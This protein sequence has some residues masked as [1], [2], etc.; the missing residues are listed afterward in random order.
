MVT[1]ER[2]TGKKENKMNNSKRPTKEWY[3][4]TGIKWLSEEEEKYLLKELEG[5]KER[6]NSHPSLQGV[7]VKMYK[8][9]LEKNKHKVCGNEALYLGETWTWKI[10]DLLRKAGIKTN[11][12][13]A[14]ALRSLART[15]EYCY[16]SAR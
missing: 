12:V 11:F 5:V 4:K 1:S 7:L 15:A 16:R 13:T 14:D 2:P 6:F 9:L 8:M 10:Q 3:E